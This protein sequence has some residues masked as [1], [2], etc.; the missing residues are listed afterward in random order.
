L[1][2]SPTR[3][4]GQLTEGPRRTG[5]AESTYRVTIRSP[6]SHAAGRAARQ[7]PRTRC[8]AIRGDAVEPIGMWRTAGCRWYCTTGT[9]SAADPARMADRELRTAEDDGYQ[10]ALCV[11]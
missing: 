1:G 10:G 3:T 4:D 8:S 11:S 9:P 2:Q 5:T 7:S 6:A